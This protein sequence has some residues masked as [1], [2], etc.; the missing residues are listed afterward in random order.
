MKKKRRIG[1]A[2]KMQ[3]RTDS[4]SMVMIIVP[5]VFSFLIDGSD[6]NGSVV[7]SDYNDGGG[8]NYNDSDV[9]SDSEEESDDDDG[10]G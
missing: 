7:D 8:Y 5:I 6:D 1:S 4:V 2:S 3:S 10:D 9:Y